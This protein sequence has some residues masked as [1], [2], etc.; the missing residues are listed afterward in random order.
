MDADA[1]LQL[2]DQVK[3]FARGPFR[4]RA[5]AADREGR[6][7][8][9]SFDELARLGVS[10]LVIPEA[11]GGLEADGET[12]IKLIETIAYGDASTAVALN[13]HLLVTAIASALPPYPRRDQVLRACAEGAWCCA[14]GSIPSRELDNTSTGFRAVE[15]GADLV[16]SGRA[17]FASGA[18]AATYA[19]VGALIERETE[20]DLVIALPELRSDAIAN[21][22]NWD[23][24][25]LRSTASHDVVIDDLRLPRADCFVA[26]ISLLR[27]GEQMIPQLQWQRRALPGLGICA[28]WLGN[29][30]AMFDETLEYLQQRRGHLASA[31][32]PLGGT[33]ELR[34]QQAWAQMALGEM[35]SW[36]A[37]G[38]TMLYHA[39]D[40]VE[41]PYADRQSFIRMQVR[42]TYHLRRMAEEVARIAI[43]TTGAHAYVKGQPLE[44]L[45][46]DL[47]GGVVMAWKTDE[48]Q[49]S[50][51][52]AAL[53]EE[54][55]I[56]G[57][58]GT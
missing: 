29:A 11:L 35:D 55:T 24:M 57:P 50:L 20:P 34:S 18:D 12:Y 6:L 46:R 2:L 43:K 36:L 25:G 52:L 54:I 8:Q 9:E 33:N 30:Q 45:Y 27:M 16:V 3:D 51:G 21:R 26:P 15:D 40:Q 47:T 17:G 32:S 49:H 7:A 5:E 10:G 48:L 42:T 4:E 23:G 31:N 14:P 13:M 28:I 37:S 19:M 38:R 22:G 1:A 56:V 58:A 39:V 44:R 41:T 53:G